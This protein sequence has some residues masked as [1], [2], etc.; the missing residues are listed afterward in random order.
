MQLSKLNEQPKIPMLR[1]P[2]FR[3][4]EIAGHT[5]RVHKPKARQAAIVATR[6][7]ETF[8]EQVLRFV[9]T[10][11]E[12]LLEAG[13]IDEDE[14]KD[15][16]MLKSFVT[17]GLMP[18]V[19]DRLKKAGE[20]LGPEHIV[21]YLENML[22]GNV[23]L[24]KHVFASLDEFDQAGFGFQELIQVFWAAIELCIYPTSDDP[25]TGDGKSGAKSEGTAPAQ[26][27]SQRTVPQ[28][29][30]RPVAISK[31]GQSAPT[32]QPPG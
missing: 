7:F 22:V 25:D 12:D 32:L 17:G 10:P 24:E 20:D 2:V 23:Q 4:I 1:T 19:M 26:P 13:A 29:E 15:V 5:V 6:L 3:D 9:A 21:W 31:A 30:K 27:A 16:D 14:A 11:R 18:Q 8:G 28:G